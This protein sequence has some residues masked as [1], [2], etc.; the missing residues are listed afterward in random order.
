[1]GSQRSTI[2]FTGDLWLP[3]YESSSI[4]SC[5][6][7]I[8]GGRKGILSSNKKKGGQD[9]RRKKTWCEQGGWVLQVKG[10]EYSTEEKMG[11]YH[12]RQEMFHSLPG[13]RGANHPRQPCPKRYQLHIHMTESLG[14][15]NRLKTI[16]FAEVL[17]FISHLNCVRK[18]HRRKPFSCSFIKVY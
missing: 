17:S 8:H 9:P 16:T 10:K 7:H 11:T 15:V 12:E 14:N 3:D 1:M 2:N 5:R 6:D 18:K 13:N 4:K